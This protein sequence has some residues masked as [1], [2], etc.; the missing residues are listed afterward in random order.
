MNS[1]RF[2][3]RIYEIVS[4]W[5]VRSVSVSMLLLCTNSCGPRECRPVDPP[6]NLCDE[7]VEVRQP[8]RVYQQM[9]DRFSSDSLVIKIVDQPTQSPIPEG[10]VYFSQESRTSGRFYADDDGILTVSKEEIDMDPTSRDTAFV[11][12][13]GYNTFGFPFESANVDSLVL[14]I[15]PCTTGPISRVVICY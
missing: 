15:E 10:L 7:S 5:L 3:A 4:Y 1:V 6:E 9:D 13:I 12:F 8:Q 2:I 11:S 14:A